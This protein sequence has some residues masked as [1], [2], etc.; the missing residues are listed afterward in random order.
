MKQGEGENQTLQ[1][2]RRRRRRRKRRKIKKIKKIDEQ[3]DKLKTE[4]ARETE[5][6]GLR[7]KTKRRNKRGKKK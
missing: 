6:Y 5:R 3:N 1:T 7:K 2:K 4:N